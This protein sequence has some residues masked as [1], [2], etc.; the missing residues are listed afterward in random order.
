GPG[1]V[2]PLPHK[3]KRRKVYTEEQVIQLLTTAQDRITE[4]EQSQKW[5]PS[6]NPYLLRDTRQGYALILLL[7]DSALRAAEVCALDC[8]QI[9][10]EE[11]I[12]LSKGGHEDAAFI[13]AIT[14]SALLELAG[15]R[16]DDAPLFV[17]IDQGRCTTRALRGCLK[18][19]ATRAHVPLV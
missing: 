2:R 5:R 19:L 8:G 7:C 4:R 3:R 1:R 12:V 9:P 6:K 11:M 13:S 14:R 17:D 15:S 10:A 18:R 16:A